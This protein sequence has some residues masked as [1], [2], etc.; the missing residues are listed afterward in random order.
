MYLDAIF[1]SIDDGNYCRLHQKNFF[2]RYFD[3]CLVTIKSAL[4]ASAT[5]LRTMGTTIPDTF[6]LRLARNNMQAVYSYCFYD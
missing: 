2:P 6:L 1:H 3:V 4:L 5:L